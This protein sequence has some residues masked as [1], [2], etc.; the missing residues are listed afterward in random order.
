[1]IKAGPKSPMIAPMVPV[2]AAEPYVRSSSARQDEERGRRKEGE[3][4][5]HPIVFF[6]FAFGSGIFYDRRVDEALA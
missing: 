5:V 3:G 2:T 1:M 6:A 4:P